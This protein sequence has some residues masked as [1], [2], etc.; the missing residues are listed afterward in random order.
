[1]SIWERWI[2]AAIS[3][4]ELVLRMLSIGVLGVLFWHLF[5]NFV[6]IDLFSVINEIILT[7]GYAFILYEGGREIK[8]RV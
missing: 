6:N 2:R 1:M 4:N 8:F 3:A 5:L 7:F